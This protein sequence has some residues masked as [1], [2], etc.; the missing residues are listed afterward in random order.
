LDNSSSA[1][2]S[3]SN[4]QPIEDQLRAFAGF[5]FSRRTMN[6][7]RLRTRRANWYR[8]IESGWHSI[9][10]RAFQIHRPQSRANSDACPRSPKSERYE[11]G[12]RMQDQFPRMMLIVGVNYEVA[13]VS[14]SNADRIVATT[15]LIRG[16]FFDGGASAS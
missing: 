15:T 5:P 4:R 9:K 10:S 12:A 7:G 14:S 3:Q 2:A 8:R 13:P 11:C 6:F 1:K 16:K